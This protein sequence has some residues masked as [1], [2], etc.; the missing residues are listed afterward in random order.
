M[1]PVLII[2]NL[3]IGKTVI[4]G[5][6]HRGN[7]TGVKRTLDYSIGNYSIVTELNIKIEFPN[8]IISLAEYDDNSSN[9][10]HSII[11]Q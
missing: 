3:K 1:S 2:G 5:E 11:R 9:F 10:I 6:G 7:I 4:Y 8:E